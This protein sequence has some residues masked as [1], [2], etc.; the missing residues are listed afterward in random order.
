MFAGRTQEAFKSKD[1]NRFW[2]PV[3]CSLT[4]GGIS[5]A[6]NVLNAPTVYKPPPALSNAILMGHYIVKNNFKNTLIMPMVIE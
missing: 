1:L 6:M 5:I 4:H 2:M 3:I